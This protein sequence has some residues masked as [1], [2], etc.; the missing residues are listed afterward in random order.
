M[1]RKFARLSPIRG[2]ST[3]FS[4]VFYKVYAGVMNTLDFVIAA[5]LQR[6]IG[7]TQRMGYFFVFPNMLIFTIFILFPVILNFVF[8]VTGG[9]NLF[10]D[11]RPFVGLTNY[12]TLFTCGN[13]MNPSTCSEDLFWRGARN[14]FWFVVFEVGGM[15]LISLMTA[16]ILNR[17]IIGRGFFRS[18]FFYPVLLSPIVVALIWKWLLQRDGLVNAVIKSLGG[19]PVLFLLDP[20]W[21]QFWVIAISI[22]AQMGFFTLILLA[23]LQSIPAELYEAGS[24][25]GA[26]RPQTF[27]FITMPLLMPTMLVVLVLSLIRAVQVFDQVFALTGGGP[28]SA[29]L[30]MVQYIYS[31]A[32]GSQVSNYGLAAAASIVLGVVLL[33]FILL[34]LRLGRASDMA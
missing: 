28:G 13:F 8:S 23:G 12:Q 7:N 17:K 2:L 22:W 21:A 14:T 4:T 10:P 11:Q 9:V 24:I 30:Y 26:S 5:P 18:V 27:R 6:I 34:Q 29:T 3:V 25:D 16:L 31:T 19:Q 33:V 15:V 1:P 20:T 32:F